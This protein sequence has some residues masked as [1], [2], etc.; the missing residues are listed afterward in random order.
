M[1]SARLVA[2]VGPVEIVGR[3]VLRDHE[4]NFSK[5]GNDGTGK[6]N[7]VPS[8]GGLVLGVAYRL[9]PAQFSTLAGIEGGY[10]SIEI[11]IEAGGRSLLA[12]TFVA[13]RPGPAPRP[14]A[15]YLEHY[16][17][18]MLEHGI[19]EDY[20]ASILGAFIGGTP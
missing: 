7:V 18:G 15:E 12:T 8:V 20:A 13:L 10:R 16:R 3:A 6:G 5:L 14:S 11:D 9:Q 1:S 2:R 19:A 17:V 4:H